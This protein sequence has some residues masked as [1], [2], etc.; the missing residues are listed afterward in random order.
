LGAC[1]YHHVYVQL[2]S[3]AQAMTNGKY[4]DMLMVLI[5]ML[6]KSESSPAVAHSEVSLLN[7]R[8]S[9]SS[10][11]YCHSSKPSSLSYG[12]LCEK[13]TVSDYQGMVDR[14]WRRSGTYFYRPWND[15]TCCPLY[16]IRLDSRKFQASKAQK[17]ARFFV[18]FSV[19]N[20]KTVYD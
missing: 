12:M 20:Q 1:Y 13:L 16:T 4:A 10:C 6:G 2:I 5:A 3:Q 14:G 19:Q 7:E 8:R 15:A 9:P 18:S 17:N 11:G